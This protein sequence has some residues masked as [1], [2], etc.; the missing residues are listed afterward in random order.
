M[1]TRLD[2]YYSQD[3]YDF[4]SILLNKIHKFKRIC[5]LAERNFKVEMDELFEEA[6][7]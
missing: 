2:E 3:F 7:N 1:R 4:R 5:K 6:D